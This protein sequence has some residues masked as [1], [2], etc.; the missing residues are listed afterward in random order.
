MVCIAT[1]MPAWHVVIWGKVIHPCWQPVVCTILR[2]IRTIIILRSYSVSD[3]VFVHSYAFVTALNIIQSK[4]VMLILI[5]GVAWA[6]LVARNQTSKTSASPDSVFRSSSD[7]H[8]NGSRLSLPTG[9][10]IHNNCRNSR[11]FSHMQW[12]PQHKVDQEAEEI[13]RNS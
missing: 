8:S 4:T 11:A 2:N 7:H 6:A 3:T 1:S 10:K 12:A 13:S 5:Y 9:N